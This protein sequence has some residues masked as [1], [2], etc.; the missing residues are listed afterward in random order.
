M[1]LPARETAD[2]NTVTMEYYDKSSKYLT[3]SQSIV[4]GSLPVRLPV[5]PTTSEQ[6]SRQID[7][8]NNDYITHS[9]YVFS[10]SYASQDALCSMIIILTARVLI[11]HNNNN[12]NIT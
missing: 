8:N 12:N 3:A 2:V 5:V 7:N 4:S 6:L 11:Y 1:V 10:R 9:N